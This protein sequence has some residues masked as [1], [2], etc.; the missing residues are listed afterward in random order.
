MSYIFVWSVFLRAILLHSFLYAMLP[1]IAAAPDFWWIYSFQSVLSLLITF[2]L[3]TLFHLSL[4]LF[5][6]HPFVSPL[7]YFAHIAICLF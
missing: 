6:C 2:C 7:R 5:L 4:L 3:L 1:L